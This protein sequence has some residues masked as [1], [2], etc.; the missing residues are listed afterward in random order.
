MVKYLCKF[1]RLRGLLIVASCMVIIATNGQEIFY[2]STKPNEVNK[3]FVLS[4]RAHSGFIF[5]HSVRVKNT[6]D[7]R[8]K[9]FELEFAKQLSGEENFQKYKSHPRHGFTF[10]YV[11]L[12]KNFLGESYSGSYFL[13]PTYKVGEQMHFLIRGSIGLSYLT[14]PFDSFTNPD[15]QTYAGHING[16]LQLGTGIAYNLSKHISLTG[17]VNFFHN[18]N[19]GFKQPNRG[20]NYPNVSLGISYFE[21]NNYFPRYKLIKDTAWKQEPVR[22]ELGFLFSPKS[23]YDIDLNANRQFLGGINFQAAKMVS[24]I[25]AVTAAAEVYYDGALQTFKDHLGD[26]TP[27]YFAGILAGHE[28]VFNRVIFSQQLGFHIYKRTNYF[29]ENYHDIYSTIYH[30]WGLRY[31]ITPHIY[32]GFNMLAHGQNADFVD[33]RASY[34]F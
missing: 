23:G 4:A 13:Q 1:G 29:D 33:V 12:D 24:N 17:G 14:N 6:A 21:N 20:V 19:G 10:T 9:G 15:N 34:K 30:R 25:S 16:F 18:S 26:K 32:G 8:P 28:F 2:D 11:D 22:Y 3:Q 27:S 31:K 5:A 7:A